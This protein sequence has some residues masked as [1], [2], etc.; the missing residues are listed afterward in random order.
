ME[1]D[2]FDLFPN[3]HHFLE[4]DKF[5][6]DITTAKTIKDHLKTL[7]SNISGNFK[8]FIFLNYIIIFFIGLV[9]SSVTKPFFFLGNTS[10]K[11]KLK[12][13]GSEISLKKTI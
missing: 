10:L 3:L 1:Q 8:L 13:N 11:M 9:T 2:S 7:V 4:T 6:I 12:C 5:K